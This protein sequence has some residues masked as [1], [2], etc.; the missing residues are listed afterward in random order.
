MFGLGPSKFAIVDLR[1]SQE[2]N[3]PAM[4]AF[5]R[6]QGTKIKKKTVVP[7]QTSLDI[8]VLVRR[9]GSFA[10]IRHT[11]TFLRPRTDEAQSMMELNNKTPACPQGDDGDAEETTW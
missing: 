9:G 2:V 8:Q 11:G 4:T 10:V 1:S 7:T 6:P 5:F 3:G